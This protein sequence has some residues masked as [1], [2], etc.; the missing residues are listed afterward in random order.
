MKNFILIAI[1]ILSILSC[2]GSDNDDQK[3]TYRSEWETC[4]VVDITGKT[5]T[6]ECDEIVKEVHY[7]GSVIPGEQVDLRT[8]YEIYQEIIKK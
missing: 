6:I 1:L 3:T 2:N 5:V 8:D 7:N 4:T